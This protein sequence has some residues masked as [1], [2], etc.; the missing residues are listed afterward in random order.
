MIFIVLLFF[1]IFYYSAPKGSATKIFILLYLV[2]LCSNFLIGTDL[3]VRGFSDVLYASWTII[4]LYIIISSWK[5]SFQ[6][7]NIFCTNEKKLN[8]FVFCVGSLCIIMTIGCFAIAYYVSQVVEDINVFKYRGGQEDTYASLGISMKPYLLAYI[9]YPISYLFVPLIFYYLSK[10]HYKLTLWSLVC[11]LTSVAFGLAYFSRSHTTQYI[12]IMAISFWFYVKSLPK[13]IRL[14]TTRCVTII[15]ILIAASFVA[16]SFSRFDGHEYSR[17]NTN[18]VLKNEV[19]YSM[20]DYFG[21]WYP[22]GNDVFNMYHFEGFNGKIAFSGI[23]RFLHMVTFGAVPSYSMDLMKRRELLLK[24]H[25]GNFIGVSSYFL[26]DTGIIISLLILLFYNK[27]VKILHS[28]NNS[29]SIFH[30]M[31]QTILI[32]LPLFGIFYS[33]LDVILLLYFYWF[34]IK[35][36]LK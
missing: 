7:E 18:A 19:V 35:F 11:S 20:A 5:S 23:D 24:E 10:R 36:M 30:A 17:Q 3:S 21:M 16:I 26:Y 15:V 12:M 27:R 9:L 25:A 34:V 13:K 6:I 31:E 2:S 14:W 22:V 29:I 1:L 28:Q 33:A 8:R 4:V 32:L